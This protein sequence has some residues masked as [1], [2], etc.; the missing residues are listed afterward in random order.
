MEIDLLLRLIAA[1]VLGAV[2]GIERQWRARMAGLRTNLLVAVGAALF[3]LLS[4]Y[5]FAGATA[6]PTRVAA[7]IVSGIGFLGAGVILREGF[8]IRGLN[9]AATLWCAAAVGSLAGAGMYLMATAGT[10]LIVGANT[11][12]RPLGRFLDRRRAARRTRYRFEVRCW[13]DDQ[14]HVRK[15]VVNALTRPELRLRSLQGQEADRRGQVEVIAT[16][17]SLR[18]DENL[19]ESATSRLSLEPSVTSV[20][21]TVE[22]EDDDDEDES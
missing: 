3:V 19:F 9:T 11:A 22:G 14:A 18:R 21:W 15:L 8:N 5:G 6:D 16:V 13:D 20:S 2:I 1:A 17:D 10:F 12:M 4:A 7:Q